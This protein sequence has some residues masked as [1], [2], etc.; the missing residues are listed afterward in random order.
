MILGSQPTFCKAEKIP[1]PLQDKVKE[2]LETM[3]R[4]GILVQ[5]QPDTVKIASAAVCQRK[6]NGALGLCVDLKVHVN[7][8]VMDEN[9]PFPELETKFHNFHVALLWQN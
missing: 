6:K 3:V 2:K 5:V 1:L 7:G 4:E 8:K 9:R